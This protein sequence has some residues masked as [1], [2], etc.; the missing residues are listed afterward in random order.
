MQTRSS[1]DAIPELTRSGLPAELASALDRELDPGETLVWSGQPRPDL[2][3]RST[4]RRMWP[5]YPILLFVATMGVAVVV[6]VI[7][8]AM[9]PAV[10]AQQ[11][12][13]ASIYVLG[14]IIGT[15]TGLMLWWIIT[16][17]GRA[18]ARATRTLYAITNRRA[19][20]LSRSARGVVEERDF[21]PDETRKVLR[22][23]RPDGAG[24]IIFETARRP[25]NSS[26]DMGGL[27]PLGFLH[28]DRCAE[29]E[30]TL[31]TTLQRDSESP[32]RAAT[33]RGQPII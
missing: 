26:T 13:P 6:Q 25:S 10:V 4:W 7:R 20:V 32:N 15:L 17:P 16:E 31:R 30:R 5:V 33:P 22:R 2:A 18:K 1:P 8:Q 21:S 27:V 28:I 24:D 14:A 23:E 11:D 3:R 9:N 19:I 12:S 29:V